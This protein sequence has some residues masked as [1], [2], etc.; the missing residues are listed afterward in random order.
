[1]TGDR[2][3]GRES[4]A[5]D[6]GAVPDGGHDRYVINVDGAVYRDGEYLLG[7][8]A[9]AEDHAAG[10][11]GLLGGTVEGPAEGGGVL[12]ATLERELH[13]EAGVE[14]GETAYVH[15]GGF[16][17]DAGTRVVQVVFLCRHR[18]GRARPR[19]PDEVAAVEWVDP[20]TVA[21]RDDLPAYTR[22]YVRLAERR[23]RDL[24]W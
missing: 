2:S 19:E 15:S 17:D 12:E 10:E 16:V 20:A 11:W 1:V 24:G 14:V 7:R 6:P 9:A 13:E 3:D 22:E 5:S 23:R 4:A 21:G 8:R 18:R